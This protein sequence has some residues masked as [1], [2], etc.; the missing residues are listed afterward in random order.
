MTYGSHS[1]LR[2]AYKQY[3]E[4]NRRKTVVSGDGTGGTATKFVRG[5]GTRSGYIFLY[6]L[7]IHIDGI[8]LPIHQML[9][10]SQCDVFPSL[11]HLE[12]KE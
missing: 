7:V 6:S 8:I 1:A 3:H 2:F 5:D 9:T 10:E 12:N 11:A 4:M